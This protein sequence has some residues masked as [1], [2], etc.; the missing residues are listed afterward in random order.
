MFGLM[1]SVHCISFDFAAFCIV[2]SFLS[3]SR[4]GQS[5]HLVMASVLQQL[6]LAM[7]HEELEEVLG[8]DLDGHGVLAGARPVPGH[9]EL[10]R[11]AHVLLQEL[12]V[13]SE[14]G[15]AVGDQPRAHAAALQPRNLW[16]NIVINH[17]SASACFK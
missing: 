6:R 14:G 13:Q 9:G 11:G 15:V 7:L 1:N 5:V 4:N 2:F 10:A 3:Y 16:T 17:N 8:P 12:L